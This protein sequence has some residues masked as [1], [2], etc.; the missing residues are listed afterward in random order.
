MADGVLT[1][2][3][4]NAAVLEAKGYDVALRGVLRLARKQTSAEE[5]AERLGYEIP[6]GVSLDFP[7][8][9]KTHLAIRL[10][11]QFD[12]PYWKAINVSTRDDLAKTV[13]RG[14]M[15]GLS[16]RKIAKQIRDAHGA[17]YTRARAMNVARTECLVGDTQV[18][19]AWIVAAH[20]REYFGDLVEVIVESGRKITGTPNHPMLT[21]RGWVAL[22]DL[23]EADYLLRH[24]A[25]GEQFGSPG[26]EHVGTPPATISQVFDSLSAVA[27]PCRER[28]GKPDFHGDGMDGYVDILRPNGELRYGRF[29]KVEDCQLDLALSESDRRT[30][31][32]AAA[33]NSFA[34]SVVPGVPGGFASISNLSARP[35]DCFHDSS[36]VNAELSGDRGGRLVGVGGGDQVIRQ[37]LRCSRSSS[38][39]KEVPPGGFNVTHDAGSIDGTCD[40]ITTNAKFCGDSGDTFAGQVKLDRVVGKRRDKDVSCHVF[41]LTTSV[42]YFTISGGFFTGNTTDAM[43]AGHCLGMRRLQEESGLQVGKEYLSVLGSTTRH[44]HASLDGTIVDG[45][46]AMFNMEGYKIPW[47][48]HFSLPARLRINCQCVPPWAIIEG[49]ISVAV[50]SRYEGELTEIVMR[51]GRRLSLTPNHPV[52]TANRGMVAAGKLEVGDDIVCYERPVNSPIAGWS[53]GDDVE[54]EPVSAEEVFEF[55]ATD[56]SFDSVVMS[57]GFI[58]DFHGDGGSLAAEI[59]VVFPHGKLRNE[60]SRIPTFEEGSTLDFASVAMGDSGL[61]SFRSFDKAGLSSGG[62]NGG[63]GG[64]ETLSGRR[65]IPSC[66]KSF[67]SASNVDAVLDQNTA[68]RSLAGLEFF[69]QLMQSNAS[70]VSLDKIVCVSNRVWHGHVYDFQSPN[71]FIVADSVLVSNCTVISA[72]VG[73]AAT[74]DKP[75][76]K[77]TEEDKREKLIGELTTFHGTTSTDFQTVAKNALAKVESSTLQ[78]VADDGQRVLLG[79]LVTN[80]DPTLKGVTPRGWP[81]GSTWDAADGFY[82]PDVKKVVATEY[83]ITWDGK[84]EQSDRVE[85]VLLHELGHGVDAA[86]K[87]VSR[88]DK[89]MKAYAKEAKALEEL[90]G[91]DKDTLSYYLQKTGGDRT[92]GASEIFAEGF[93]VLKA[94]RGAGGAYQAELI[95]KHF[96]KTLKAIEAATKPKKTKKPRK[97]KDPKQQPAAPPE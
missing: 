18:D 50:R 11:E 97:P 79:D 57:R 82:D 36:P 92:A 33:R 84:K 69:R 25:S 48:G 41:N 83:R 12:Q 46:D 62:G 75:D 88:S 91:F 53:N 87:T 23:T 49:N 68:D 4:L 19:G 52:A 73:Q 54:N 95:R 28:T 63:L 85:G 74:A 1:E 81:P 65:V 96:P 43:N 56:T 27:I 17:E 32:L 58:D 34:K 31:L 24:E 44:A 21:Q 7:D 90:F 66:L 39:V 22:G 77:E 89:F 61:P 47:P 86:L 20:K 60:C 64:H 76:G 8:W 9:L 13:D 16:I 14:L 59:D 80:V 67:G 5:I 94:G 15:D 29:S 71:G 2:L 45:P 3:F 37:A 38:V 10:Q 51:S 40:G 78:L 30:V 93:A 42:G 70:E 35:A 26:D 55:F 72:I 6:D